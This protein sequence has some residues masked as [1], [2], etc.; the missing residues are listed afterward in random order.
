MCLLQD[1]H[2]AGD[3]ANRF[4]E[5]EEQAT[6]TL[7]AYTLGLSRGPRADTRP[8]LGST[9]ELSGVNPGPLPAG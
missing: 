3:P 4:Q 2:L 6:T 7:A 5:E 9:M 1:F 8:N